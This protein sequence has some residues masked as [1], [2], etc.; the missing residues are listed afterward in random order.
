MS[1]SPPE[2]SL[3]ERAL[4]GVE[5]RA[6]K[7]VAVLRI[8]H[9]NETPRALGERLVTSYARRA[10]LGGAA[11]GTLSLITLPVGLP[12]GIALTLAVEAELLAS[13]LVAYGH[14]VDGES[15]RAK[16]YAL[17]AGGALA[18]AAKNA[19]LSIGAK[20]I[21]E[22]LAGTLPV[23]LVRRLQPWLVKAILKR[24]G[25]GWVPGVLKLWPLVGAPIGYLLDS[26]AVKALGRTALDE[27]EARVTST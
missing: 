18:D 6:R 25:L 5:E 26:G 13:L 23:Q 20:A 4:A 10:G 15:G 14:D 27:L 24:L 16:L 1:A 11:T 2:S 3:L 17:W 9:P 7:R 22:V 12:A 8:E 21:G 19:G